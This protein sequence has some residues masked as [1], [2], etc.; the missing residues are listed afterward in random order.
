MSRGVRPKLTFDGK[1]NVT[2][3]IVLPSIRVDI[4]DEKN[5]NNHFFFIRC[6]LCV[7]IRRPKM[8]VL[9]L[10]FVEKRKKKHFQKYKNRYHWETTNISS[11]IK[12]TSFDSQK[13]LQEYTYSSN[14]WNQPINQKVDCDNGLVLP[15]PSDQFLFLKNAIWRFNAG[16]SQ[17]LFMKNK[18]SKGLKILL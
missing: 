15:V 4:I 13:Y 9:F 6:C 1:S 17:F 18:F 2:F 16:C 10:L 3:R 12:C 14:E 11:S 5:T 8:T 7:Y